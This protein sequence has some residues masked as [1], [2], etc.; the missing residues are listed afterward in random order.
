MIWISESQDIDFGEKLID[1]IRN[2]TDKLQNQD[3]DKA[4]DNFLD[5]F[6]NFK[7]KFRSDNSRK[8]FLKDLDNS[9]AKIDAISPEFLENK[10][11]KILKLKKNFIKSKKYHLKFWIHLYVLHHK[12]DL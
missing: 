7:I 8:K 4:F 2:F 9:L 5:T 12:Q 3:D 10:C 1:L 6:R 11:N